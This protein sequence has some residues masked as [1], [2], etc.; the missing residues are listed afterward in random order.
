MEI[1]ELTIRDAYAITPIIHSDE[2][3]EFVEWYRHDRL[4]EVVGYPLDLRQANT[5]VSHRGVVRG[6]HFADV[7]RGQAKYVTCMSG[8]IVDYVV[9]IRVGSPTFGQYESVPLSASLRNAVYLSEGLGHAF[10]ALEDNTVVSYLVSD[11]YNPGAE[12]GINPRDE[13][14]SLDFGRE[15]IQLNLSPK[16]ESAPTLSE[17]MTKGLLPDFS[18]CVKHYDELRTSHLGGK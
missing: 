12:H 1:R 2:R 4:A 5:S 11:T 8:A 7:P 14:L 16:D 6:I 17:L 9:D 3:G 10:I 18:S 15:E 13:T